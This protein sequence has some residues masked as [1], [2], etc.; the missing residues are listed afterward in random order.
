MTN[1][2]TGS[3]IYSTAFSDGM[4]EN[5]C[6]LIEAQS[7]HETDDYSSNAFVKD[8]NCFGYK[9]VSG[10][11]WQLSTGITSSEGD[12]YARYA[13]IQNSVHEICDWIKRRQKE[14][15]FPFDLT[16][17]S[18]PE[19]YAILLKNCGY[20]GDTTANYIAGITHFLN[21]SV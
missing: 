18:T 14:H 7:K 17:V 15:K 9:Y 21:T 20:Y 10:A 8:N 6:A 2:E 11:H 12:P 3:L 5:L 1:Q 4:P 16:T 13:S 19:T